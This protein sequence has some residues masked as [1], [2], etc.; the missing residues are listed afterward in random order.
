MKSEEKRVKIPLLLRWVLACY[1]GGDGI[2][3]YLYMSGVDG[4]YVDLARHIYFYTMVA[5]FAYGVVCFLRWLM[6]LKMF[7]NGEFKN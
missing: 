2:N 3:T 7:N 5:V 1:I 4:M 6:S